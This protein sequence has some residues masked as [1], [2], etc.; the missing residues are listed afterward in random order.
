LPTSAEDRRALGAEQGATDTRSLD[1]AAATT[2]TATTETATTETGNVALAVLVLMVVSLLSVLA[3]ATANHSIRLGANDRDLSRAGGAAELG[4]QEAFARIDGGETA[5]FTGSGVIDGTSYDYVAEP[6]SQSVWTIRSEASS[7]RI[8]RAFQATVGRQPLYPFTLFVDEALVLDRNTGTIGGRVGTNGTMTIT[9]PSPSG[10]QELYRPDGS[11]TGCGNPVEVDGP[12]R[13]DPVV[14]PS[15]PTVACPVDG[16]FENAIDG[17]TGSTVVCDDPATPVVFTGEV[18]IDN[19]PLVLY[20]GRDVPL[21]LDG[22]VVNDGGNAAALQLHIVGE[23]TDG[24]SS[25]SATGAEVTGLLY[26]PGRSLTTMDTALTGSA[27][28][29]RVDL[30]RGGRLTI[31]ADPTIGPLGDDDWQIVELRT[32]APSP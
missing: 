9:G 24:V 6:T 25:I 23:A 21:S 5:T 26:A 11:C 4:V 1:T 32:V 15:G 10:D 16:R 12:R 18:T 30:G 19:P 22:A 31:D 20:V 17:Q 8:S 13:L 27:T 29:R 7:G 2:G 3:F 14:L 28:L